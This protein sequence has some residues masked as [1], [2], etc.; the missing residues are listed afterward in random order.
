MA[1]EKHDCLAFCLRFLSMPLSTRHRPLVC[2]LDSTHLPAPQ[3]PSLLHAGLFLPASEIKSLRR[4]AVDAL[5]A[6]RRGSLPVTRAAGLAT[7]AVLPD[8]L[9]TA[10]EAPAPEQV[11]QLI[12]SLSS[13]TATA[14]TH[15]AGEPGSARGTEVGGEA[16]DEQRRNSGQGASSSSSSSSSGR[17]G[18]GGVEAAEG[19]CLR[20]LCR[21]RE[22]VDAALAVGPWL[23]EVV[24]D[25]LEVQ[26]LKEA[27]AAVSGLTSGCVLGA[28]GESW[29]G[30]GGLPGGAGA[31]WRRWRR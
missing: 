27:V 5:L 12:R 16:G 24:V 23:K 13:T 25:F 4:R 31:Q 26:G 11:L 18:G 30:S 9:R 8:M 3:L 28:G 15:A 19:V 21:S 20:V 6:A 14:N 7:A 17:R 1:A 29:V 22:Q 10:R 2:T